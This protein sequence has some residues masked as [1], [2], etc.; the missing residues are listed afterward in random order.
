[1]QQLT[2]GITKAGAGTDGICWNILGQTYL[3]TSLNEQSFS[4][5]ATVPAGA[6][7]VC[8]PFADAPDVLTQRS[9]STSGL[10][11]YCGATSITT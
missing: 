6:F 9:R 11:E 7:V 5:H 4:W 8:V 2:A 10:C 3:P 1:M